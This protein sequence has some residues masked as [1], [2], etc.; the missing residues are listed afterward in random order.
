[1]RSRYKTLLPAKPHPTAP[2]PGLALNPLERLGSVRWR[3]VPFRFFIACLYWDYGVTGV[4]VRGIEYTA[5][6]FADY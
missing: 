2:L 3:V 4:T 5:L 6:G 1:M